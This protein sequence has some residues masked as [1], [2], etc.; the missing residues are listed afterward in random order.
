M[1]GVVIL[2]AIAQEIMMEQELTR[3]G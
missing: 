1:K 3:R 2:W